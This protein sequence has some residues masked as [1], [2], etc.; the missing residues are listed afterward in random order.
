MSLA[1]LNLKLVTVGALQ[2]NCYVLIDPGTNQCIVIDPGAEPDKILPLIRDC[3]VSN[4]LLT[5]G[6]ADHIG[7]V[8]NIRDATGAPVAVRPTDAHMLGRILADQW[9]HH[10]DMIALGAQ[11]IHVV[12]TPGHTPGQVSFVLNDGRAIVGDTIFEGGPGRTWCPD[13]FQT[14]LATLQQVVLSWPDDTWCYPGHGPSFLLGAIRARVEAFLGQQHPA[15]FF[16]DASW[17]S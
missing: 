9:L 10:G 12:A 17:P 5:H 11:Q 2:E 3:R 8:L 14:T 6:H 1:S 4:I 15:N 16:G 13:D 7:A